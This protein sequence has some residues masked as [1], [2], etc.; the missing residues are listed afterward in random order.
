MKLFSIS[1][2]FFL[3]FLAQK[4]GE[5]QKKVEDEVVITVVP[6]PPPQF[7]TATDAM[8]DEELIQMYRDLRKL[9]EEISLLNLKYTVRAERMKSKSQMT[10][11]ATAKTEKIDK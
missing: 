5:P 1:L 7:T 3:P 11:K 2:V 9:R 6:S 4:M 8:T 10:I